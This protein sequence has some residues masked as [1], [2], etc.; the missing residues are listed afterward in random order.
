[1]DMLIF[2]CYNNNRSVLSTKNMSRR[3]NG[4]MKRALK[5][6]IGLMALLLAFLCTFLLAAC[7]DPGNAA[8]DGGQDG[9][10]VTDEEDG[11]DLPDE[12]VTVGGYTLDASLEDW[13]ETDRANGLFIPV[14]DGQHANVYAKKIGEGVV[15]AVEA[16]HHRYVTTSEYTLSNSNLQFAF[17][18]A[19]ETRYVTATNE[20][21]GVSDFAVRSVSD[22]SIRT[23]VFELF[24]AKE[25]IPSFDA[26]LRFGFRLHLSG[27]SEDYFWGYGGDWRIDGCDV[28]NCS[29]YLSEAGITGRLPAAD[30]AVDGVLGAEWDGAEEIVSGY[31]DYG[32]I[33]MRSRMEEDGVYL[34]FTALHMEWH[35]HQY[36]CYNPNFEFRL[37]ASSSNFATFR[38]VKYSQ[39]VTL[40]SSTAG[41]A[42][43]TMTFDEDL[44]MYRTV[45]EVFIP[46]ESIPGGAADSEIVVGASFRADEDDVNPWVP[47][48]D[49]G[50][51]TWDMRCLAITQGG[52]KRI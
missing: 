21:S 39:D 45:C 49:N 37:G 9:N 18:D 8:D 3:K 24:V 22:G 26:Q 25:E 6:A 40:F 50:S 44:G 52:W 43:M 34:Y 14:A 7:T 28:G 48:Y 29:Y 15:L 42:V 31:N 19:E 4:C 1:M 13:S 11:D 41:D 17:S 23:T 47:Y 38:V 33:T 36:W 46:Y 5:S 27:Y 12:A 10:G 2:S 32:T 20:S 30:G 51:S 16:K 35:E